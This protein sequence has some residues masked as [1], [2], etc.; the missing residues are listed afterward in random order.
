MPSLALKFA[1]CQRAGSIDRYSR[2]SVR[3]L[4]YERSVLAA[5]QLNPGSGEAL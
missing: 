5:G 3:T 2:A 4:P 1:D